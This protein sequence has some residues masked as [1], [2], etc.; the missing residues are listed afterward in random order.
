MAEDREF[1]E[2]ELAQFDEALEFLDGHVHHDDI[3][4][5]IT[6]EFRE[7]NIRFYERILSDPAFGER[8]GVGVE[9]AKSRLEQWRKLGDS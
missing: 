8:R 4:Q 3:D 5:R 2:E 7:A 1:T 9:V 6:P